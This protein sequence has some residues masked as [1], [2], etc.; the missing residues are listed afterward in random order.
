MKGCS[1]RSPQ[2]A[3]RNRAA[4]YKETFTRS[5]YLRLYEDVERRAAPAEV[6]GAARLLNL[7]PGERVLDLACGYGRHLVE[8]ERLG[9]HGA[10][11]DLSDMLLAHARQYARRDGLPL[12]YVRADL[13]ALPFCGSFDAAINFFLSFGYLSDDED[14]L[15]LRECLQ[16]LRPGGRFLLDSWNAQRVIDG[17]RPKVVEEREEAVITERSW[18][19]PSSRRIEWASRAAFHDGTTEKWEC[20]VRAYTPREL[21]RLVAAVG[22]REVELF[23]DWAGAP[24]RPDSPR[25]LLRAVR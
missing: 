22:F 4:W 20:S 8:L 17:L 2:S 7:Q 9:I 21:R 12:R 11:V 5:G 3:I 10:G 1:I 13:R 24:F 14:A 19:D 15:V 16:V 6:Q 25:L 23:G 18:Y